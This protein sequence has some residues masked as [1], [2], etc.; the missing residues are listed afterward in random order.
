MLRLIGYILF[1]IVALMG[2]VFAVA[3]R[4]VVSVSL[5]PFDTEAPFLA[6][7]VPLFLLV[8]GAL[9]LGV[10]IGGLADWLSQ[11][12]LRREMREEKKQTK[13]LERALE[14]SS[15]ARKALPRN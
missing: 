5:D 4:G 10:I 11:G 3:N 9:A 6:F 13:R 1:A 15:P 2:I 12:R 8:F 14:E 7:D